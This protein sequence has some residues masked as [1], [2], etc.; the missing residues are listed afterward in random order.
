MIVLRWR[1]ERLRAVVAC[2]AIAVGMVATDA[3][4]ETVEIYAA[5]SLRTAVEAL[6]KQAVLGADVEL[7]PTFGGSGIL[8]QRIEAGEHP[9]LF[10][11]ADMA[12]P[13]KL[14]EAG[15]AIV[16]VVPF[17]RN[18][19]CL[20]ARRSVSLTGANL[21]DRMLAGGLRLKTSTPVADPAG[22][23]AMAI[24]DRIDASRP[25][26]GRILRDKA[27]SLMDASAAMPPVAGHS[28]GAS[29]FLNNQIDMMVTYC[30]ATQS[31]E[32]EVPELATVA[33]PPELEPRPVYGLALLSTK[34]GAMRLALFLLSVDGQA[35]VAQA[36]LLPILD[37]SH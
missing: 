31:I 22:D 29:L 13:R 26:A 4:A 7:K 3:V 23:Y 32:K 20:V 10:L 6:V 37:W 17:A 30:S 14:A 1:V 18:K 15:R 16:P 12:S 36:G 24:F 9:D 25:G 34:P 5:G 11:S 21:V 2:G 35:I 27:Q 33:F 19:M 8:R 28:V